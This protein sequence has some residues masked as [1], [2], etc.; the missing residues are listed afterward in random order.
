MKLSDDV[1]RIQDRWAVLQETKHWTVLKPLLWDHSPHW[2][3]SLVQFDENT[4]GQLTGFGALL[5][6]GEDTLKELD[7]LELGTEALTAEE[8]FLIAFRR[9]LKRRE[10]AKTD[11]A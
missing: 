9:V 1:Q 3:D 4:R 11:P 8:T 6:I 2:F 7:E 10:D 5:R